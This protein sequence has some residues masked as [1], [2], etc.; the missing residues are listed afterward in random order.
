MKVNTNL[1]SNSSS[2]S[3]SKEKHHK[4]HSY[5]KDKYGQSNLISKKQPIFHCGTF[6]KSLSVNK[7]KSNTQEDYFVL[8]NKEN[9]SK[10]INKSTAKKEE[11]EGKFILSNPVKCFLR[12]K[13]IVTEKCPNDNNLENDNLSFCYSITSSNDLLG[14]S[15]NTLST[16]KVNEEENS[17]FLRNDKFSFNKIFLDTLD[18]REI[19]NESCKTTIDD[20]IFNS[21]SGLIFAYGISNSGKTHSIIGTVDNQGFLPISLDYLYNNMDF[22][23]N[24]VESCSIE[25]K[26]SYIEIYNEEIYDLLSPNGDSKVT[27]REVNKRFILKGKYKVRLYIRLH[28]T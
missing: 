4:I 13:P 2:L 25:L 7:F 8:E 3:K 1:K 28:K 22:I 21:K 24:N 17:F 12:I 16:Y 10:I 19:W 20:F 15:S 5:S 6:Q 9:N 18:Q 27:L 11:R 14:Q 23:F 26:C